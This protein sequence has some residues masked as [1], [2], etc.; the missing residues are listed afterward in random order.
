MGGWKVKET[1]YVE[2]EAETETETEAET[3]AETE[4]ER[5]TEP[6][7]E[8]DKE[9]KPVSVTPKGTVNLTNSTHV[10]TKRN[11]TKR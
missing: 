10:I 5:D 9:S 2:T 3:V 1:L 7:K 4:T 6:E 8:P 11:N